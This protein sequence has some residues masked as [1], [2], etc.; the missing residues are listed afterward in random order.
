MKEKNRE[1]AKYHSLQVKVEQEPDQDII[2]HLKETVI[3]TP[4]RLMYRLTG[5]EKKIGMLG[6]SYF[7]VLRKLNRLIGT[8]GFVRRNTYGQ[9][10]SHKSWYIR[11]FSIRAPLRTKIHKKENYDDKPSSGDNIL[12]DSVRDYF[13]EPN[14]MLGDMPAPNQKTFLYA[15]IERENI[16]SKMFSDQMDFEVIRSLTTIFFNRINPKI[17]PG[18]QRIK[19][20]EKASM[21][22]LLR[23][24]Y[25]GFNMY[26]EQYLFY[27]NNYYLL[28]LN[29]EIVAGVQANPETWEIIKKPGLKGKIL[30]GII[31][32]IPGISRIFD[33]QNFRFLAIEGIYYKEGYEKYLLPLFETICALTKTHFA[34]IWLDTDSQVIRTINK[35]GHHGALSKFIKRIEANII[36][37]FINFSE[38]EKESFRNNPAYLSCFDMT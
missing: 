26:T 34:F 32:R 29:D 5:I 10:L 30:F 4:G 7:L 33:P 24:F 16:R 35:L 9:A 15:Y 37:K 21:L 18:V 2:E 14:R 28:K 8:I 31:P 22:E 13:Y 17:H 38:Q 25:R 1:I 19:E 11:Y 20:E 6:E 23:V 36:I 12:K 3:G 27:E